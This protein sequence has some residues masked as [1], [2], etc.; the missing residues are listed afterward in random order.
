ME[1]VVSLGVDFHLKY[2]RSEYIIDMRYVQ[3][4][5]P[6]LPYS[7]R[8]LIKLS[9]VVFLGSDF[10]YSLYSLEKHLSMSGT[11]NE[12]ESKSEGRN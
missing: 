4:P 9:P 12:S 11:V 2:I 6:I 1:F 5:F 10:Q 8:L 3:S 7:L